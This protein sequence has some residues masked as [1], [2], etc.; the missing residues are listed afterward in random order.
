VSGRLF[1][2]RKGLDGVTDGAVGSTGALRKRGDG[3]GW[4]SKIYRLPGIFA[5]LLLFD[6][7]QLMAIMEL[8]E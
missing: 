7:L 2:G 4:A 5:S 1:A 8:P 3:C 6:K